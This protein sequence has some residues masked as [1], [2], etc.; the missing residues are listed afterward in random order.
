MNSPLSLEEIYDKYSAPEGSGDKGT[1]HSYIDNYYQKKFEPIRFNQLNILEIG[2][3][4][5]L[6][7]EMWAEYFPNSKITGVEIK[8]IPYKPSNERINLVIGDATNAKTFIGYD[9]FDIIIDDGS[10]LVGDQLI[11]FAILFY[12]LKKNGIYVIEDVREIEKSS[13]IFNKLHENVKIYD[14]RKLKGRMDDVIVEVI[15]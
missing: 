5:G 7:L 10:H 8:N 3:S 1:A 14:Y 12:K 11:S 15:K 13:L 9:N 4:T 2:V 6:S